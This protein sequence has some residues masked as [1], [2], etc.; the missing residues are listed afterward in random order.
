MLINK[1][2]PDFPLPHL[3]YLQW[4]WKLSNKKMKGKSSKQKNHCQKI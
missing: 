4:S 3:C 2:S 1:I